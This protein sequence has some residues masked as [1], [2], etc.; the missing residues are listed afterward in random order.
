MNSNPL[1]GIIMIDKIPGIIAIIINVLMLGR[2]DARFTKIHWDIETK[3][4]DKLLIV[5][6]AIISLPILMLTLK[7]TRNR[8]YN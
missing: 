5:L 2:E 7:L 8:I 3:L 6:Y 4:R 1:D